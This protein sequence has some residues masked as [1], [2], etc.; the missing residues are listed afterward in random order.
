MSRSFVIIATSLAAGVAAATIVLLARQPESAVG[1]VVDPSGYFDQSAAT[2]DRIGALEAAVAEERNARQLL[3][4]ELQILYA[5]VDRLSEERDETAESEA[6]RV[7][8]IRLNRER[9]QEFR[10]RRDDRSSEGR[11]NQLVD[12]G[13]PPDRAAWILQRE[14]ELQMAAMQARFDA[15]RG[16][17][18]PFDPFAVAS[19]PG[20][21]LRAEI[22]DA[23]YEQYLQ[24]INR[25]TAVSVGSVLESSPGQR[26]GL[27]SGDQIVSYNGKRV[28][29][30]ADLNRQIMLGE[31]GESVVVDIS[32]DGIPIQ[33]VMPRGPIGIST[34]RFPRRR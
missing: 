11:V 28:Y 10:Q 18:E 15:R 30:A 33:V 24:A 20:L 5:E 32:R 2:E 3:E 21:A 34:G 29:D 8:D 7:A 1:S 26:A 12:A 6:Q 16:G 17:G 4:D 27:Q 19:N 25:P 9:V 23:E 22:G 13:F 31:P 14:S